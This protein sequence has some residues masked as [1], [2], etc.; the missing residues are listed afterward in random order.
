MDPRKKKDKNGVE[1]DD[2]GLP[3]V[4]DDQGELEGGE[5]SQPF[6]STA[7][8]Y[9]EEPE[10]GEGDE[11]KRVRSKHSKNPDASDEEEGELLESD[12]DHAVDEDD[13][14]GGEQPETVDESP[15][16]LADDDEKQIM[17]KKRH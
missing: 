10:K 15:P 12:E 3:L 1:G 5:P 11:E 17:K 8:Y 2:Q 7:P 14:F 16:D 6:D 4:D 13:E 9:A